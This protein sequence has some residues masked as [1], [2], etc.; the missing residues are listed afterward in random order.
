MKFFVPHARDEQETSSVI[1][2]ISEFTGFPIPSPKI[3][4]IRY[5]H[6][7]I[8]MSATVGEDPY[9]YYQEKGPVIAILEKDGLYAICTPNRGVVRGEPILVGSPSVQQ[10]IHFD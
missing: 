9:K 4:S 5:R 8:F 1:K 6:N 2:L 3:Y 10:V 7:R